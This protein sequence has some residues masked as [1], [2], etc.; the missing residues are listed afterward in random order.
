[1]FHELLNRLQPFGESARL[2]DSCGALAEHCS[3]TE[4]ARRLLQH[5]RDTQQRK[6]P[7]PKQP[8]AVELDGGHWQIRS[9]YQRRYQPDGDA[10]SDE[11]RRNRYVHGYRT[12]SL[13][14]FA[15]D[16]KVLR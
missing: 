10:A 16:L 15:S 14:N 2:R 4:W 5:H 13:W 9:H 8:W 11:T 1:M 7:V 3:E 12:N 6:Q